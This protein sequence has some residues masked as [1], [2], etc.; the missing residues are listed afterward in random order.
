MQGCKWFKRQ[1][2]KRK[3]K[4]SCPSS[5]V[6]KPKARQLL[7]PLAANL[8]R[9]FLTPCWKFWLLKWPNSALPRETPCLANHASLQVDSMKEVSMDCENKYPIFPWGKYL[10]TREN[11]DCHSYQVCQ[12]FNQPPLMDPAL[13]CP[14]CWYYYCRASIKVKTKV[15][16]ELS[17]W[18]ACVVCSFKTYTC[19]HM[20]FP[21]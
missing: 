6:L 19:F 16:S 17:V 2:Q 18:L 3:R 10:L 13:H 15:H 20:R 12:Q 5:F 7:S 21:G 14:L 1:R 11:F 8:L 9:V 4:K